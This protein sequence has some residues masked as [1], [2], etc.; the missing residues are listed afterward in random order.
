MNKVFQWEFPAIR[1]G[2]VGMKTI[3]APTMVSESPFLAS[4]Y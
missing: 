3:Y 4:A 2:H 1:Y